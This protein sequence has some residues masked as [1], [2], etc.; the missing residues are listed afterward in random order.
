VA[1]CKDPLDYCCYK[2]LI[3]LGIGRPF[4]KQKE[5]SILKNVMAGQKYNANSNGR[6]IPKHLPFPIGKISPGKVP[7]QNTRGKSDEI[8][9]GLP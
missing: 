3:I 2:F 4:H 7:S 5:K 8:L 9:R 6:D 1:L